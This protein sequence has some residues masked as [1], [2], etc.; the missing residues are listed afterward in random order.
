MNDTSLKDVKELIRIHFCNAKEFYEH[1]KLLEV[2][3]DYRAFFTL[4]ENGLSYSQMD[5]AH[6][7]ALFIKFKGIHENIK[8][9][10]FGI[11]LRDF[12]R[13][14]SNKDLKN[15][16]L[17][18]EIANKKVRILTNTMDVE[19]ELTDF[20]EGC[21][22][23]QM[24]FDIEAEIDLKNLLNAIKG[25][26]IVKIFIENGRLFIDGR[27]EMVKKKTFIPSKF[28]NFKNGTSAIYNPYCFE[29]FLKRAVKLKNIAK[30][31]FSNNKPLNVSLETKMA[32][33]DY[34]LAPRVEEV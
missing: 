21:N 6:I 4:N 7:S 24:N 26:E 27:N 22:I 9:C 16:K 5:P 19:G 34:Y 23:P 20:D 33:I 13:I 3:D 12:T 31:R 10:K 18:F 8:E 29:R 11:Y 28:N 30:L 32:R 25:F 1:L 2:I 15:S 17:T 14:I